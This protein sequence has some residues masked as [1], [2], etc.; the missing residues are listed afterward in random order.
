MCLVFS[1]DDLN[2]RV[3]VLHKLSSVGVQVRYLIFAVI[4]LW[5]HNLSFHAAEAH[6]FLKSQFASPSWSLASSSQPHGGF[7]H[8]TTFP[9]GSQMP[10]KLARSST[11]PQASSHPTT[12]Q[13]PSESRHLHEDVCWAASTSLTNEAA[14]STCIKLSSHARKRPSFLGSG[15]QTEATRRCSRIRLF[16]S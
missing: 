3:L 2:A 6:R 1:P 10:H 4:L 14:R 16:H 12:T 11:K 5:A 7:F 13:T 9:P 15:S 8:V